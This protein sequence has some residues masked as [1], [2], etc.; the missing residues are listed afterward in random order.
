MSYQPARFLAADLERVVR[1]L[2]K[3]GHKV[4]KV[5]VTR[6]AAE[7]FLVADEPV[8]VETRESGEAERLASE[9]EASWYDKDGKPVPLG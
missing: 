2:E 3:S 9:L 7:V 6:E 1:S 8:A 5:R 4:L